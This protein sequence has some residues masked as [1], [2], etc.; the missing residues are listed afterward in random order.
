MFLTKLLFNLNPQFF[1][2]PFYP[3]PNFPP[4]RST[5]TPIFPQIFFPNRS[6]P[7]PIFPQGVLT[8]SPLFAF[9]L[10]YVPE[11]FISEIRSFREA[12]FLGLYHP[13]VKQTFPISLQVLGGYVKPWQRES[14]KAQI[15]NKFLNRKSVFCVNILGNIKQSTKATNACCIPDNTRRYTM[16]TKRFKPLSTATMYNVK[17]L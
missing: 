7:T 17:A 10:S 8:Q 12:K 6:T 1:S 5:P 9:Y 11:I 4:N 2:K 14:E 3:N 16:L 13:V 15:S